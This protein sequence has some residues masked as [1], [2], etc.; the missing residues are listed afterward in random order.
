MVIDRI[1]FIESISGIN[2]PEMLVHFFDQFIALKKLVENTGTITVESN[3]DNSITFITSF[4]CRENKLKALSNIGYNTITIYGKPISINI[5]DIS[6]TDIRFI[7][8]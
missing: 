1:S 5:Q 8:Q 4:S 3:T 7:L 2:Y 6:D